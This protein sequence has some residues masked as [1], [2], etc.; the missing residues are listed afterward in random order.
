MDQLR[1]SIALVTFCLFTI[2]FKG[3][4]FAAEFSTTAQVCDAR[5]LP[6]ARLPVTK[7]QS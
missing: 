2:V 6:Q 7:K 4:G 1:F 3:T 5:M